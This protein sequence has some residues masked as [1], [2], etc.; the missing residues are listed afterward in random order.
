MSTWEWARKPPRPVLNRAHGLCSSMIFASCPGWTK[1]FGQG[2][3]PLGELEDFRGARG[4]WNAA[5][6]NDSPWQGGNRIGGQGLDNGDGTFTSAPEYLTPAG[7]TRYDITNGMT[8]AVLVRPDVLSVDGTLPLFKH[9][10]QPYNGTTP[11]WCFTAAAGNVWRF[12]MSDGVNQQNVNSTTVQNVFRGDLLLVTVAP[13]AGG[14]INLKFY[15]NGVLEGSANSAT[16][17]NMGNPASTPIKFLGLG[18]VAAGQPNYAGLVSVGYVWDR[19]LSQGDINALATDPF[20]PYRRELVD[21]SVYFQ[22]QTFL[23]CG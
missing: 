18:T 5:T 10:N 22:Y 1:G 11:G 7:D 14:G 23:A 9:M 4:V 6:L 20:R 3:T 21:E 19:V 16:I 8:A 17:N 15:T 2:A 12:N 13:V